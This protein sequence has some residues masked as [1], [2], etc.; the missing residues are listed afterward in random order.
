[1]CP[2]KPW[3]RRQ[4]EPL[5]GARQ[6]SRSGH[7]VT[8]DLLL[9]AREVH[10]ALCAPAS[11]RIGNFDTACAT[12]PAR[13]VSSDFVTMFDL[14]G[15]WFLALGDLMGKGLSA[16]M[17]LTHVLDLLRRACETGDALPAIM[18]SLNREVHRSRV[19]V[20]LTSLF[21]ARLDPAT[22]SVT[23]S[24][25]GC[26]PAFL[27]TGGQT[28][29]RLESSGPILGA[30]ERATYSSSTVVLGL[31]DML[32]VASDGIIEVH[33]GTSFEWR[34]DRVARHLMFTAGDSAGSLVQS[35]VARVKAAAPAISHDLSLMAVQRVA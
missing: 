14:D 7:T 24:C 19:G 17:W 22:A 12:V 26:P 21:L 2:P 1:M 30:V 20:P 4:R 15:S 5:Q 33:Q 27:L 32:L 29:S 10:D 35:L 13:H 23:Y 3:I 8:E 25:G 18:Q 11:Q 31:H 28:V 34:P 16:A 6:E 9:G